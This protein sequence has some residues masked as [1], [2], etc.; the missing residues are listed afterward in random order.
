MVCEKGNVKVGICHRKPQEPA[1]MSLWGVRWSPWPS[2]VPIGWPLPVENE[3][4]KPLCNGIEGFDSTMM[5]DRPLIYMGPTM[6]IYIYRNIYI[7]IYICIGQGILKFLTAGSNYP[8]L[9]REKG[10]SK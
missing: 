1:E 6:K 10:P 7:Y 9:W 8:S 3:I 4:C 2:A 5:G